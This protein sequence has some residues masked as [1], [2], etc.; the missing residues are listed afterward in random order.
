RVGHHNDCF[1]ASATDMGTYQ[2]QG[3]R[4]YAVSDSAFVPIGGETCAVYPARSE[5]A[6]AMAEMALL[7]FGFLNISYHPDVIQSWRNGGWFG[8]IACRLGYRLA[9]LRHESPPT[10]RAGETLSVALKLVND[11]YARPPNPR[12]VELVLEGPVRRE[13]ATGIDPRQWTAG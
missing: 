11:G 10:L 12:G 7:R 9:L 13:F 4:D 5:C 1:L 6:P 2:Q 8:Q 3:E